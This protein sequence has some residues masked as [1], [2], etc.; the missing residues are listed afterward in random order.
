VVT[1]VPVGTVEATVVVATG[2]VVVGGGEVVVVGATVVVAAAVVVVVFFPCEGGGPAAANAARCARQPCG[3]AGGAGV[4]GS[5]DDGRPGPAGGRAEVGAG[6]GVM[7]GCAVER[8]P[9]PPDCDAAN[10]AIEPMAISAPSPAT[11]ARRRRR[12][13]R[14]RPPIETAYS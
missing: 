6:S 13:C 2:V 10:P 7:A 9:W 1:V 5:V 12:C 3:P 11:S 14:R 8:V 4:G